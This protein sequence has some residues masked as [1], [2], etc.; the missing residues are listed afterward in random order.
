MSRDCLKG[1]MTDDQL[2]FWTTTL[3]RIESRF[4]NSKGPF[5]HRE[6]MGSAHEQSLLAQARSIMDEMHIRT[7]EP[8]YL[9]HG[10]H[11][12]GNSDAIID[13][14]R[15]PQPAA[16]RRSYTPPTT[17]QR[18]SSLHSQTSTYSNIFSVPCGTS[19]PQADDGCSE[20]SDSKLSKEKG[21]IPEIIDLESLGGKLF[22]LFFNHID[23]PSWLRSLRLH[24]YTPVF[25]SM[26]WKEMVHLSDEELE[27]RG[28]AALGAR[29]KML[30]VF[31]KIKEQCKSDGFS[32]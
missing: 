14:F 20:S 21:K 5:N 2:L 12:L 24:K 4:G 9:N 3:V 11:A 29:R 7:K 22:T 32:L 6:S 15:F 18:P 25:Q 28:V 27:K 26:T 16:T 23:I 13:S 17:Q 1:S 19:K 10:K 30:K 31:E 8:S